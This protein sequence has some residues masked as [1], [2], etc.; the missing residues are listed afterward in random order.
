MKHISIVTYPILVIK[1]K[2]KKL[3]LKKKVIKKMDTKHTLQTLR[4]C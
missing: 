2:K 4:R 3:S 1:K